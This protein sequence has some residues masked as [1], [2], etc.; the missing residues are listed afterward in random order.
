MVF[1]VIDG[2]TSQAYKYS[3]D[4]ATGPFV[5]S[6]TIGSVDIAVAARPRAPLAPGSYADRPG[7]NSLTRA[8]VM[9]GDHRVR[10][11]AQRRERMRSHLLRSVVSVC[12]DPT[13]RDSGAVNEVVRSAGVSRGTFYKYFDSLDQAITELGVQ[14]AD[15]MTEGIFDVYDV[16]EAPAERAATGFLMFLLRAAAEPEWGAFVARMGLLGSDG[17]L[18]R[19]VRSDVRRGIEGGDFTVPSVEVATDLLMGAKTEAILRIISGARSR[20]YIQMMTS[21][22]LRSLGVPASRA[23]RITA[24]A[25]ERLCEISPGRIEWW[26]PPAE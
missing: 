6:R 14:L 15:E 17:L 26:V 10:V 24:R 1:I 5:R 13:N 19:S 7:S 12:S 20:S 9:Q 3:A 23:D 16:I 21:M 4:E 2:P 22:I 8:A 11:A 25:Y 18:A